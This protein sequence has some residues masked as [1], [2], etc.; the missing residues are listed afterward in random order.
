M[1]SSR[2]AIIAAVVFLAGLACLYYDV[3]TE[4]FYWILFLPLKAVQLLATDVLHLA[5]ERF[6]MF[7]LAVGA[8][9]TVF[10][11]QLWLRWSTPR[12]GR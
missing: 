4:T 5:N 9:L 8:P 11:W 2:V 6:I 7:S 3:T 1:R 10:Y 12:V